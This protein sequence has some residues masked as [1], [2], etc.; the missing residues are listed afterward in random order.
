MGR[1]VVESLIIFSLHIKKNM[2]NNVKNME[3][4]FN[5][6][7]SMLRIEM[8][9]RFEK[10]VFSLTRENFTIFLELRISNRNSFL[11]NITN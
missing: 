2:E 5:L 1:K 4:K 9:K 6:V 8:D 3:I 7:I 10:M 11:G